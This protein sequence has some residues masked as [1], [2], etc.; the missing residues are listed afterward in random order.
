MRIP[1]ELI[2]FHVNPPFNL[3]RIQ[4]ANY[5]SMGRERNRGT[6]NVY[7]KYLRYC[8]RVRVFVFTA[9]SMVDNGIGTNG[10]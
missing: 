1:L 7:G 10:H 2:Q 9:F 5:I 4:C 6:D 3:T 8:G